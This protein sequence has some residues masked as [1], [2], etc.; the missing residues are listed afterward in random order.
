MQIKA[1]L[2]ALVALVLVFLAPP[3][4]AESTSTEPAHE[5]V[6]EIMDAITGSTIS[7]VE[8]KIA[9]AKEA[10]QTELRVVIESPGGDVI[11]GLRIMRL[12]RDSGMHTTCQVEALAASMAAILL[13]SPACQRRLVRPWSIVMFHEA[14]VGGQGRENE[15]AAALAL[16]RASNLSIAQIVAPRLGISVEDY[17]S[18]TSGGH[19]WWLVGVEGLQKNF[20]DEIVRQDPSGTPSSSTNPP[21]AS[22]GL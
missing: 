13:E 18:L 20:A 8:T 7:D 22:N 16:L 19:E 14:A 12:L 21:D 15:M 3:V 2:L 5:V 11:S 17:Q 4:R 6:V 9:A 1:R 10:K